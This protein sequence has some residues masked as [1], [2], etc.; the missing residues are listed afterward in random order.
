MTMSKSKSSEERLG[1]KDMYRE[2]KKANP[3][4]DITYAYYRSVLESFSNVLA[5]ELLNGA[6]F[7]MGQRLGTLRIKRI[8]RNP[9]SRTVDWNATIQMWA[10]ERKK[11]GFVYWTDETYYRWAWDKRKAIVKNKSAYRFDPT[12]GTKGLKKRLTERL[13]KDPFAGTNYSK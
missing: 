10:E 4:T 7:N 3:D 8:K 2:F 13:R 11:E 6:T 1:A 12:G 9:N 5:E